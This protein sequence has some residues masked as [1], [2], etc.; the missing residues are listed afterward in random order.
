MASAGFPTR[1]ESKIVSMLTIFRPRGGHTAAPPSGRQHHADVEMVFAL[2]EDAGAAVAVRIGAATAF[3]TA[4]GG[5]T[6]RIAIV[7]ETALGAVITMH[8]LAAVG[9]GAGYRV[10]SHRFR[11]GVVLAIAQPR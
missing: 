10:A 7:V 3:H 11:A 5:S 6:R 4:G 8:V 2:P 9:V 1:G